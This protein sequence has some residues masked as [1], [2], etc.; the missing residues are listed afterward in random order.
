MLT[1]SPKDGIGY[2]VIAAATQRG[3]KY[4]DVHGYTCPACLIM[5]FNGE[6]NI[7]GQVLPFAL[8]L[9]P[10]IILLTRE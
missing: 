9:L 4:R 1:N 7:W 8:K 5:R 3:G 2:H 6:T 10:A